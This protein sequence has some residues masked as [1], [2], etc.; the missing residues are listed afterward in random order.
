MNTQLKA[1]IEKAIDNVIQ[2]SCEEPLWSGYIHDELVQQMTD[3]AEAVFD[4]AMKAQEF[5]E[6]Q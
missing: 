5:A 6:S 1:D 2:K 3:A 4:S